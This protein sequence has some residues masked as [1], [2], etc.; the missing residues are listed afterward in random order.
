MNTKEYAYTGSGKAFIQTL[1]RDVAKETTGTD[2]RRGCL[3]MNTASEFAQTDPGIAELVSR[4]IIR[5]QTTIN[6]GLTFH[7]IITTGRSHCCPTY[8]SLQV[9][10]AAWQSPCYC[11]SFRRLLRLL[12][13]SMGS[14][15]RASLQLF[16]I[17]PNDKVARNDVLIKLKKGTLKTKTGANTLYWHPSS[18]F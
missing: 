9:A 5:G 8:T 17:V 18:D 6:S 1:F 15:L 14:A 12:H 3:L 13:P 16:L 4:T 2:G 10:T 11:A 7:K